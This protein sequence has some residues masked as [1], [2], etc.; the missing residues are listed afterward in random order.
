VIGHRCG[1]GFRFTG[2]RAAGVDVDEDLADEL[3][4]GVD[5]LAAGAGAGATVAGWTTGRTG[6]GSTWR[7][8]SDRSCGST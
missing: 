3:A 2:G 5:E 8:P 7:G 1:A 4:A 6:T